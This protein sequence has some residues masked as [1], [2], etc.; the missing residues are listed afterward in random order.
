[1]K[2]IVLPKITLSEVFKKDLRLLG[3]LLLNGVVAFVSQRFLKENPELSLIFGAAANYVAFRVMEE[4]KNEGYRE[5][6]K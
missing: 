3:F 1:M 4:M 5:A 2:K 6:L